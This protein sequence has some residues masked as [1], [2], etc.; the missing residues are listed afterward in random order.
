MTMNETYAAVEP[1]RAEIDA[2]EGPALLE[3]GSAWCGHCRAAQPL[4][5]LALV[6]HPGVRHLKIADGPGRPLGRSF[7]VKL[8][9]TLVFLDGGKE[10]SRL[11]RP[12]D[13]SAIAGAL[14]EID[15][16]RR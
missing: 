6:S 5:A 11:V 10:Q 2:L 7:N 14:A 16:T 15:T 3:F 9:P 13:A 4:I 12:A 8:W 1:A